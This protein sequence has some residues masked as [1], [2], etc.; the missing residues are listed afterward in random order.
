MLYH[1]KTIQLIINNYSEYNVSNLSI[2][3]GG[4]QNSLNQMYEAPIV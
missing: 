3:E 1:V 4:R 2:D